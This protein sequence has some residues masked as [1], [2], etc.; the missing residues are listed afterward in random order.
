MTPAPGYTKDGTIDLRRLPRIIERPL[1]RERA[2]GMAAQLLH[3]DA[4]DARPYP[5]TDGSPTLW[6]DTKLRGT[7]AELETAVH[8]A[9]HLAAP[10]LFEPVVLATGRYIAMVLWRLGFRRITD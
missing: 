4:G 7:R 2:D 5:G 9:L 10:F 1:G 8:E 3:S 6:L